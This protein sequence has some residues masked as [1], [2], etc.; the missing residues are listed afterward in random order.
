MK[1]QKKISLTARIDLFL[2]KSKKA[3]IPLS[4]LYYGVRYGTIPWDLCAGIGI[5]LI[6]VLFFRIDV[7]FFRKFELLKLYPIKPKLYATYAFIVATAGFWLWALVQTGRRRILLQQLADAFNCAGLKN[8]LGKLPSFISDRPIDPYTRKLRLSRAKLALDDFKNAKPALESALQIYIDDV[9]EQREYGTV[10][11][12]YSHHP[13]PSLVEMK[14][15]N[16]ITRNEF[17]IGGTR[18]RQIKAN[19]E[20]IPHLLVAGQTNGGKS[21]FL[22]QFITSLYLNNKDYEFTLVDLKGGLEFQ[23]F[24]N[25]ERVSVV[26]N[27]TD[28]ANK[29]KVFKQILEDRMKILKL[30]KCKDIAQYLKLSESKRQS[31]DGA[32]ATNLSRRLIVIDEAA[33]IFL[34]G[35]DAAHGDIQN[36]RRVLVEIARKGRAVGIHIV[37]A[38]QRP[39]VRS[40]DSQVKANLPGILCFQMP[41]DTSSITVL[42][43]GRATDLPAIPGR[44]IWKSGATQLEVQTPLLTPEIAEAILLPF[45]KSDQN[46]KVQAR[47]I[48]SKPKKSEVMFE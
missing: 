48:E 46:E 21:T 33:D 37:I 43:N 24:E 19:L 23:I 47:K 32:K 1:E 39:D 25:L 12:T 31:V 15:V 11:F 14:S 2:E 44:A 34:A 16:N 40:I 17:M 45:R 5:A 42:G 29:L 20:D 9:K 10:E 8:R 26:A 35:R 3:C 22:R 4:E 28:A 30:N 18:A 27:L 41:N 36:A 6:A 7:L 38:T 13:M